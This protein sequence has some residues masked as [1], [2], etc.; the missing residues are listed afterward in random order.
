MANDNGAAGAF[1]VLCRA[2]DG[3]LLEKAPIIRHATATCMKL[4]Y[5]YVSVCEL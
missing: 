5:E 2:T 3:V 4:L 1:S